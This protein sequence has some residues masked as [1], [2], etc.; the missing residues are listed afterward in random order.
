MDEEV[1]E[2]QSSLSLP[3][4]RQ[5]LLGGLDTLPPTPAELRKGSGVSWGG[6][7]HS[8]PLS[9]RNSTRALDP[10]EAAGHR[11]HPWVSW[12]GCDL[13]ETLWSLERG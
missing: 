8:K 12:T 3:T 5:E 13:G 1:T 6:M 10:Q 11:L 7:L 4:P 9:T 2:C